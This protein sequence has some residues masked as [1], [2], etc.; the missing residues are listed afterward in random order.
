MSIVYMTKEITPESLVRIYHALGAALPGSVAVKLST[1]EPGGHNFLQPEL[2][3]NLVQE[4]KGTIVE[5][6]TAYEGR[7][8]TS[9]AHWETIRDH[10]FAAIAPCDILDED[11]HMPL[12]VTGG[13]HLKENYVGSHLQNYDSMLMLSHFKGHAMGGF[14]GALKNMSI[15]LASSYG[16]IWIHSSGTSTRFEDV[17]T[18]DHDSFLESMADADRSVMDY[19]GRE[20]IVYINVANRLSVDCDCDAHPHDPE[21]KD[22][23]IFASADPVALDQA[24]VDA[25]Y[26]SEDEGKAALIERMESRNG[27]HTVEAA[28]TLGLGSRGYELRCIDL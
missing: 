13:Y 1:G 23:G 22:I 19:M 15:G 20:N 12:P 28:E 26:A 10:G 5:C 18:A 24:C 11:G 17:F 4:L 7:R 9:R 25:V 27:I 21:M 16:K 8:N 2:I 6:N 3:R 14:G